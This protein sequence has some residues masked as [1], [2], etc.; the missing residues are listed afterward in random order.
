MIEDWDKFAI[1]KRACANAAGFRS[2]DQFLKAARRDVGGFF[3]LA[4]TQESVT[5]VHSL[6]A[7]AVFVPIAERDALTQWGR[8]YRLAQLQQQ[9][10]RAGLA[11][12]HL[13]VQNSGGVL[14]W[15]DSWRSTWRLAEG[16]VIIGYHGGGEDG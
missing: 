15:Q 5:S 13:T 2:G 1:G 9:R 14:R 6:A 12:A 7:N 11:A 3:V 16:E 4:I 8:D 10:E